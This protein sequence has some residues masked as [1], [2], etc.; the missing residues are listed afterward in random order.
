MG[1]FLVQMPQVAVLLPTSFKV[2]RDMRRGILK[3]VHSHGPWCLHLVEGRA[4]EQSLAGIHDWGCT[5]LIGRLM[6]PAQVAIVRS[7]RIPTVLVDPQN[8][9]ISAAYRTLLA[10]SAL[11][12]CDTE[13][14]GR[15]AAD[16][17]LSKHFTHFAY[18]DEA[19]RIGWSVRRGMSFAKAVEKAGFSCAVYPRLPAAEQDDAGRERGRLCAW[20]VT[21]PKPVAV[22][23]AW[24]GRARQVVD[25]CALAGLRIP[26]EVAILG[27]DN[28]EDLCCATVPSLSSIELDAERAAYAA[29]RELDLL[30]RRACRPH[31]I[32]YGPVHVVARDSTAGTRVGDPLV[33][34]AL[35][36]IALNAC[37]GI[38][39]PDVAR[40]VG[41]SRRVLERRFRARVGGSVLDSIT[42]VRLA[43]VRALLVET[44]EPVGTVAVAAGFRSLSYLGSLFHHR[45]GCS[46][47]AYRARHAIV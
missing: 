3:Y 1:N 46:M 25:A 18:I 23:A 44:S 43:R 32:V 20:L 37:Q 34:R 39:V 5:G 9:R 28:D 33:A 16:H 47:R 21:L 38:G 14:V 29:A 42:E 2:C 6:T 45:Y 7:L 22:L 41:V 40:L 11:V 15:L 35:E 36:F 30:M 19:H 26:D 27:V 31:R 24:D 17:F 4:G 10:R 13:A 12:S 8:T